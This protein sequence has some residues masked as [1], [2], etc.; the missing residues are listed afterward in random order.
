[1]DDPARLPCPFVLQERRRLV[2][3]L[4]GVNDH[5]QT[6][7]ARQPHLPPERLALLGRGE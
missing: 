4:A 5:R 1:M 6:H 3:R 7:L 2:V